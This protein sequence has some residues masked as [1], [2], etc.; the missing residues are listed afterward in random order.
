MD[1]VVPCC[2]AC[3]VLVDAVAASRVRV[4]GRFRPLRIPQCILVPCSTATDALA[5]TSSALD[6][7]ITFSH[8]SGVLAMSP[9][10]TLRRGRQL[11]SLHYYRVGQE[12]LS[13]LTGLLG[14]S[15]A[16]TPGCPL[17]T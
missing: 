10:G 2:S 11:A 3:I 1:R 8:L 7:R 12:P 17:W 13:M 4:G 16:S 15:N 9:P 6:V 14:F 5:R